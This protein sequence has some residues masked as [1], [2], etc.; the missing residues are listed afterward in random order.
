MNLTTK[1]KN[2][3]N[4]LCILYIFII[5]IFLVNNA[6]SNENDNEIIIN[7]DEILILDNGNK[8]KASGDIKIKTSEF[9]ST[10]DNSTYNKELNQIKSSGNI[11]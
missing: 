2:Y 5:T 8:I 4:L 1:I 11:N 10:S 9:D 3:F 7:A 6:I